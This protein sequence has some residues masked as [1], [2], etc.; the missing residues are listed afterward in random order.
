MPLPKWITCLWPL[1]LPSWCAD[2]KASTRGKRGRGWPTAQES[3]LKAAPS[4][5]TWFTISLCVGPLPSPAAGGYARA[6]GMGH[7]AATSNSSVRTSALRIT[8]GFAG[9]LPGGSWMSSIT[10]WRKIFL[11]TSIPLVTLPKTV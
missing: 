9:T 3:L 1:V 10:G 8:T 7:F 11:A 5:L 4:G 2:G 6:G